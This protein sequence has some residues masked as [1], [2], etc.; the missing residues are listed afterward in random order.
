MRIKKIS[1]LLLTALLLCV[2][3]TGC[4]KKSVKPYKHSGFLSDYSRLE[5]DADEMG[6]IY[7]D[8]AIDFKTYDKILLERIM[9]WYKDDSEHKGIDPTQLKML[10]DYFHD[11]IVKELGDDYPLVTEPGPGVLRIRIAITELIPA[12]PAM[13]V[14]VLVTP[15]A[16]VADMAS[17]AVTKGD[18][19]SPPYLGDTAIEVEVIDSETNEQLGAY[20]ERR[21][22]KKYN[23][24]TGEGAGKAVKTYASSYF[25]SYSEWGYTKAAFDYWAKGLR[26]RL[27]EA[28]GVKAPEGKDPDE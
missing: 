23:V 3:T 15:Y 2:F 10:T 22:P 1:I 17:G 20:V 11:A 24:D 27:D 14:V 19:G 4:A 28:R 13:S 8:P 9:V 16:T 5:P 26:K 12:K 6:E 21:M 25:K 18:A 7:I